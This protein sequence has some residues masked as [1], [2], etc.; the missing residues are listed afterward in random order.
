MF[1][2]LDRFITCSV[3]IA[4]KEKWEEKRWEKRIRKE[5]R[6]GK[7]TQ[8]AMKREKWEEKWREEKRMEK[9]GIFRGMWCVV[10]LQMKYDFLHCDD[11]EYGKSKWQVH[12]LVTTPFSSP[13]NN[14]PH[15]KQNSIPVC[16][17]LSRSVIFHCKDSLRSGM[18][19]SC[20]LNCKSTLHILCWDYR[21]LYGWPKHSRSHCVYN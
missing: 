17:F 14:L 9:E 18:L 21:K 15:N 1:W 6:E 5:K 10:N 20:S 19:F 2:T 13:H 11:G 8:D 3:T 7:N 4:T 16:M 12:S